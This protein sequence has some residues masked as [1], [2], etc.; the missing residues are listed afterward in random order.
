MKM[1]W[2]TETR[3]MCKILTSGDFEIVQ[4]YEKTCFGSWQVNRWGRY[5]CTCKSL[6]EAKE[7]CEFENK[8]G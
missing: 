8:I 5:S 7:F 6:K 3:D 4:L 2:I 1:K